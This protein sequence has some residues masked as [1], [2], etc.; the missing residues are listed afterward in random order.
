MY[1]RSIIL[2]LCV[3]LFS[4][5]LSA[6]PVV[7]GNLMGQLGNQLF[8]IAATV[9]LALDH[10]AEAVF[11]DLI[12]RTQE[13]LPVNREK[14]LYRCNAVMPE[15]TS[16]KFHYREPH[17]HYAP[18]PYQPNMQISG[19]FQSEKYFRNHK[20]EIVAL[21]APSAEIKDYLTNKYSHLIN[22]PCSVAIH[23]RH[24]SE[25]GG[26]RIYVPC[27]SDYLKKAMALYP[28][29]AQFVVC[30]NDLE[31]TKKLF[32]DLSVEPY[33]VENEPHYHDFYLMSMCKHNIIS[34]SSYSWWAAY[35]NTNPEKIVAAPLAWFTSDSGL[36]S[37]DL[38][39]SSWMVF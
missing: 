9:S 36:D 20:D 18:I 33:Y 34:N 2:M 27:S 24:Y 1:F 5:P 8:I 3:L 16:L 37:K 35:L 12:T 10:D 11:P 25:S 15:G 14:I 31:R 22:H 17:F 6:K 29:E 21:F 4:S 28:K 26:E 32:A 19:Y 38:I 30:T 23:V 7:K 13:G 39:P